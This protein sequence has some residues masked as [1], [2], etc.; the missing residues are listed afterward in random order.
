MVG[1]PSL[2]TSTDDGPSRQSPESITTSWRTPLFRGAQRDLPAG[3]RVKRP[4]QSV[5]QQAERQGEDSRSENWSG[6]V[7]SL[8]L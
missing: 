8:F 3:L 5:I 7:L 1:L 2:F 6:T 4:F